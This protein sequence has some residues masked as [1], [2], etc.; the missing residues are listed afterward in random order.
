MTLKAWEAEGSARAHLALAICRVVVARAAYNWL[1]A[2]TTGDGWALYLMEPAVRP[3]TT[4]PS[5]SA[6]RMNT[7]MV[8]T[9][10]APKR[11]CQS[12]VYWPMNESSRTVSG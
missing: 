11:C 4:R 5:I 3:P 8:A 6:N 9:S 7:G 1:V 10:D 12:T 2:T